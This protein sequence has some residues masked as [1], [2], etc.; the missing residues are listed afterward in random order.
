MYK[1]ETGKDGHGGKTLSSVEIRPVENGYVV[2]CTY[3]AKKKSGEFDYPSMM[4]SHERVFTSGAAAVAFLNAE[5]G[6]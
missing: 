2:R 6:E 4:P 3:M 1:E 5:L